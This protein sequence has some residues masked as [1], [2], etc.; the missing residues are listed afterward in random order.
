MTIEITIQVP[1]TLGQQLQKLSKNYV[2]VRHSI[3]CSDERRL[4]VPK[5]MSYEHAN[6]TKAIPIRSD[7]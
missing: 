1:D 5:G 6:R 7:R 3:C 4:I 2:A